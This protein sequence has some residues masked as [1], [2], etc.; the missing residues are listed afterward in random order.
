VLT[1]LAGDMRPIVA[2]DLEVLVEEFAQRFSSGIN[3]VGS[4]REVRNLLSDV[5]GEDHLA[6]VMTDEQEE[7]A[8]SPV[9]VWDQL[10][11]L[12]DDALRAYLSKE[13]PQT[14]AMVLSK[15]DAAIA[16]KI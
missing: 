7:P 9:R 16:A 8:E 12:K 13:H 1:Q 10:S 4:E 15:I 6:G 5:M 3:F 2:S 11:R 14:A